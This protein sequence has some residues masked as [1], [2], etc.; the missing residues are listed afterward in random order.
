MIPH[1]KQL[2]L[3]AGS[4]I[5]VVCLF[6]GISLIWTLGIVAAAA[7]G[8]EIYDSFGYGTPDIQDALYTIVAGILIVS[9]FAGLSQ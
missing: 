7:I 3:L 4:L 9:I 2:H 5:A 8:K 1:D 6:F